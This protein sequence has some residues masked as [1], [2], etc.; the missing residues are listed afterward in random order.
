MVE[1]RINGG[2]CRDVCLWAD[3]GVCGEDR[4]GG[5]GGM[6][7]SMVNGGMI[8]LFVFVSHVCQILG[9]HL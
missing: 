9:N 6:L 5:G 3:G 7:L 4:F 8:L 1:L 2:R